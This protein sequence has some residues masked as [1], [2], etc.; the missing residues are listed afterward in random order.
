MLVYNSN[1]SLEFMMIFVY[2]ATYSQW[3]DDIL[4]FPSSHIQQI[5]H[6][7]LVSAGTLVGPVGGTNL[8]GRIA[9]MD[10]QGNPM[11]LV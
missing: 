8:F 11:N 9:K 6:L 5:L 2:Q 7:Q 1:S 4:C 10:Y 3:D